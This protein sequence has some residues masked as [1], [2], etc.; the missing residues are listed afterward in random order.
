MMTRPL[1]TPNPGRLFFLL[2][3]ASGL[4]MLVACPRTEE[5]TAL[6]PIPERGSE[7]VIDP[8]DGG[9]PA[10][11]SKDD[12]AGHPDAGEGARAKGEE[13]EPSEDLKKARGTKE[14]MSQAAV[15]KQIAE[16][17]GVLGSLESS[18]GD[19]HGGSTGAGYGAG[20]LGVR[21]TGT[22]GGGHG[23][24]GL[25][26]QGYGTSA[27]YTG[28]GHGEKLA[29]HKSSRG[30]QAPQVAPYSYL[31]DPAQVYTPGHNTE[32][33]SHLTDNPF[34]EADPNPLS[35]FSIDVDTAS[36]A[37]V[38][39][40]LDS[41]TPPPKD[42]VRIEEMVNYFN[43]D[44]ASPGGDT[45]FSSHVEVAGCPWNPDHRLARIG[46]K[47]W[48]MEQDER[49]ASNLVFLLDVSGSMIPNNKLPLVVEALKLLVDQLD[50]RDRIAIAVYAGASGLVLPSTSCD[51]KEAILGALDQLRSGGSTN[52]G[53]GIQLAYDTAVANYLDG[54]VNRVILATDGDFNVGTTNSGG[55]TRLIED[56][57]KSGVFLSVLGFGMG[58][59]KDSTLETLADK[60]N[61]NY[62]YIDTLKEARKV[63]VD[64]MGGTLVT[65]AKDVK[66]QVEFNPAQVAAYRLIGYENRLLAA[67]D[68][69]DDTKDA[70]EIGAGHTVTAL[71][72]IVPAGV[73]IDLP[74][75]DPLRYQ[76]PEDWERATS[77]DELFTLKLRYKQPDGD[78]SSKLVFHVEDTG[79]SY[80][81]AST[82]FK[83]AA[84]VAAFGMILRDS[85]HK[86]T[87]TY[88]AILELAG[89]GRGRDAHGYRAEFIELVK[90][91]R[92]LS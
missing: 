25:A 92:S 45:P 9:A 19:L 48:E 30:S 68:F 34:L 24:G 63:L 61:G 89:E 73:A 60:G 46:L 21:G 62:A 38:R 69:N 39:R 74:D 35:T 36:Y 88:D 86:G 54:G 1:P 90:K 4:L 28:A 2:A 12:P 41:A 27:G 81:G 64:E 29:R 5:E 72:E 55:L 58:N 6:E 31:Q 18:N 23:H 8:A 14:A 7:I 75:I 40:F 43:Y 33:Y 47:G 51:D 52:G 44:Y 57:A 32:A 87:A 37:N 66:I 76:T 85:P 83:F 16:S 26:V 20:G 13:G 53:A 49:P 10:E 77:S 11:A 70:G 22:S 91:A 50:E 80:A 56:K 79:C 3:A 15:D 65:I 42:A 67:Q 82:D 78:T 71:Y 59:I 17:A 84:S